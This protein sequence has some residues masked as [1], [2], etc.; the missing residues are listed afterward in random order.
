MRWRGERQS[1]NIEDRRGV[2]RTG[3][4]VGGGLGTLLILLLALLFGA[5]P[6]KILEQLPTTTPS[7]Q[8][9][10]STNPNEEELKQFVSVVLAKT[11]DVWQGVFRQT[12]REYRKPTLVLFTDQVRSGCG[13]NGAAVHFIVRQTKR[14]ISTYRFM[15]SCDHDFMHLVTLRKRMSLLTR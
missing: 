2:S 6:R 15:K 4:A 1:E 7:V 11:E 10:R 9:T 12:G 8:S 5:D 13:L 14:Y 3:V